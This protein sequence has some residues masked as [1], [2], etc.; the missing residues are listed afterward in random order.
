MF[1]GSG[2]LLFRAPNN[3][4]MH[5]N[6]T[7]IKPRKFVEN[8][9]VYFDKYTLLD[10][11]NTELTFV[12]LMHINRTRNLLSIKAR[13]TVVQTLALSFINCGTTARRTTNKTQ[14]NTTKISKFPAKVAV[15]GR[16]KS[17]H[18]SPILD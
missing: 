1:I 6:D 11:H 7:Q 12:I 15:G 17:D 10:T 18:A 16:S 5:V 8:L 14:F 9:G 2:T 13:T 3:T 4:I